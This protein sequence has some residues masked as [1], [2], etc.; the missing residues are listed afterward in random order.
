MRWPVD[1]TGRNSVTPSTIPN[2]KALRMIMGG[3]QYRNRGAGSRHP[4]ATIR[5]VSFDLG[6]TLAY[7]EASMWEIFADLCTQ[8]GVPTAPE[9]CEQLVRALWNAG[10]E[11]AEQ[12]F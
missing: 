8:A 9:S 2:T 5:A 10:A 12:R 11:Q 7:P 1:D 4:M 6:W 3:A